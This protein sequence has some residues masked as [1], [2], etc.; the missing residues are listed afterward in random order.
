LSLAG[1]LLCGF[2]GGG[3]RPLG[4]TLLGACRSFSLGLRLGFLL[5]GS[6]LS[7]DGLGLRLH[8]SGGGSGDL[9]IRLDLGCGISF[10]SGA[11]GSSGIGNHLLRQS[12]SLAGIL[13]CG[14]GSGGGR[15]LGPALL[16]A[17][18]SFSLGLRLG[19]RSG[20]CRLSPGGLGL[21]LHVSGGGGGD[22]LV[23]HHL[24]CSV[25]L[26]SGRRFFRVGGGGIG[27][28]LLRRSLS[29]SSVLLC[30]LCGSG[31]RP[32][33]PALLGARRSISLGLHLGFLLGDSRLSPCG[34]GLRL[35]FDGGGGGDLLVGQRLGGGLSLLSG[36]LHFRV[37][38]GGGSRLLVC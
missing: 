11:F 35:H 15:P 13:L 20:D 31:G 1:I 7:L 29:L 24:G 2:G 21:Q 6:R 37:G 22:L 38:G 28:H 9:L 16:S 34:G 25:S 14:F 27:N 23:S 26:G 10:S 18:R 3:G 8:L 33:R 30:R 5:G 19:F 36:R 12:L 17:C 4:P 32:L